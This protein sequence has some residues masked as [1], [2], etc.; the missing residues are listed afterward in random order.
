MHTRAN[1]PNSIGKGTTM[2]ATRAAM[3]AAMG[4]A[5]G[6]A[7]LGPYGTAHAQR[8]QTAGAPLQLL[9]GDSQATRAGNPARKAAARRPAAKA[10]AKTKSNQTAT[11]SQKAT[12]ARASKTRHAV[13]HAKSD[14]RPATT[15]T[16]RQSG[17]VRAARIRP[18][19]RAITAAM[20]ALR[21]EEEQESLA[22]APMPSQQAPHAATAHKNDNRTAREAPPQ[23]YVMRD[24]DS[25][26]LIAR[27]PWWRNGPMQVIRYG[28]EEARSQVLAAADAWLIANENETN[29]VE[30]VAAHPDDRV[31]VADA[32]EFN[33][34]DGALSVAPASPVPPI[35]TFWRSLFAIL[36]GTVAAALVAL[37][38]ARY[39]FA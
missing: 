29:D 10:S 27:L 16:A 14:S 2:A 6:I 25:V 5:L 17:R 36:A 19:Q 4:M 18:A 32:S 8:S 13:R 7:L 20:P 24:G 33:V 11:T 22:F 12:T 9:P 1:A 30:T 31:V 37:A 34:I 39:L 23:D 38:S 21:N 3:I 28:S 15:H 35:P 26:A